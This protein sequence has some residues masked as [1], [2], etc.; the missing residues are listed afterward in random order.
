MLKLLSNIKFSKLYYG[1]NHFGV[2][3]MQQKQEDRV[4]LNSRITRFMY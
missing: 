4:K 1:N 3:D 2:G